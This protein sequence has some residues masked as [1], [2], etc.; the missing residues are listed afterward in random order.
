MGLCLFVLIGPW[1]SFLRFRCGLGDWKEIKQLAEASS[2]ICGLVSSSWQA[3]LMCWES[4]PFYR[5]IAAICPLALLLLLLLLC[6]IFFMLF[7]FCCSGMYLHTHK[8]SHYPS[9]YPADRRINPWFY[10]GLGDASQ[11]VIKQVYYITILKRR[12]YT[13][14]FLCPLNINS[15][16]ATC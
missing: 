5:Y 4:F 1:R 16:N 3:V 10:C 9:L 2:G 12:N 6:F 15:H 11:L 7:F 13:F 8:H 14:S